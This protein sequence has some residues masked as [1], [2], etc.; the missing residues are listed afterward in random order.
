MKLIVGLG[1]PGTQYERTRHNVGFDVIDRIARRYMPAE[2]AKSRFHGL[3]LDGSIDGERA[4]LLKPT[5][6]MNRSGTAVSEAVT[7]Y[8]LDPAEA[9]LIIVDDVALPCGTIRIRTS[10]GAGGHNGLGDIER[11]IGTQQYARLRIGIDPPGDA[12]QKD[13]V[14]GRFS[15][16]QQERIAPALDDAVDACV[17]W[18]KHGA[19]E[20]MNRFNRRETA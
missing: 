8:K 6:Y 17:C 4:M 12:P 19:V 20:A 15:P 2:I 7:F 14:L 10:G 1:N 3:L 9:L 5:T 13:Y 11:R 16:E 18:I